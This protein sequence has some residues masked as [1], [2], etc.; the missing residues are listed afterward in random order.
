MTTYQCLI[1]LYNYINSLDARLQNEQTERE[2]SHY[3]RKTADSLH[4]VYKAQMKREHF[5]EFSQAVT[6]ILNACELLDLDG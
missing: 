5:K 1:G 4:E 3:L 2:H 6:R